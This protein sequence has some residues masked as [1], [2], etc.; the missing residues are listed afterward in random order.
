MTFKAK[1]IS[2]NKEGYEFKHKG[3]DEYNNERPNDQFM[4]GESE[5]P[6]SERRPG[7]K[8][9]VRASTACDG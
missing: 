8:R 7:A 3:E 9:N 5:A 2:N 1:A 4:W 6:N